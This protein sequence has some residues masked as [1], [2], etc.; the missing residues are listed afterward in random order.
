MDNTIETEIEQGSHGQFHA[1]C[2]DEMGERDGG[3]TSWYKTAEE[4]Q[5]AINDYIARRR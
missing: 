2:T 3:W 1:R 5:A 4:A